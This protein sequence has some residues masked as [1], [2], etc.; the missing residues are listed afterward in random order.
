MCKTKIHSTDNSP[1]PNTRKRTKKQRG[2]S[3]ASDNVNRLNAKS[4]TSFVYPIH[5]Q[6]VMKSPTHPDTLQV[7][8]GQA[9][10]ASWFYT[11]FVPYMTSLCEFSHHPTDVIPAMQTMWNTKYPEGK[12]SK[13]AATHMLR[14]F[15]TANKD[16]TSASSTD[17]LSVPLSW[18]A[19]YGANVQSNKGTYDMIGGGPQCLYDTNYTLHNRDNYDRWRGNM[20]SSTPFGSTVPQN[21]L[22]D[23]YNWFVGKTTIL[24]PGN[25][26][27][28]HQNQMQYLSQTGPRD[29][30]RV[31]VL[32]DMTSTVPAMHGDVDT[33]VS[34]FPGVSTGQY[35][36][37]SRRTPLARAGGRRRQRRTRRAKLKL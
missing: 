18:M 9:T 5:V 36:S 7:G 8:G 11:E 12:L 30:I 3:V 6:N 19:S 33:N 25:A 23:M 20:G 35:A 24:A 13:R 22:S 1:M 27:P 26:N 29:P 37:V 15:V 32:S 10:S 2:G 34:V 16:M 4:C 28:T 17:A 21:T 31:P 14:E